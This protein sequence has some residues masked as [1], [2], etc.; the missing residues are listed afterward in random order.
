[1]AEVKPEPSVLEYDDRTTEA[2]KSV[3][4][5]MGQILGSF[6]GKFAIVGGLVPSLLI[7]GDEMKHVGSV[8]IDVSLDAEALGDGEYVSL[9]DALKENGYNQQDDLKVF[10][11]VRRIDVK[12]GGNHIDVVVDFLMPKSARFKKNRPPR[13]E[14]FVVIKA[15]GADIAL[16][17]SETIRVKG[18]MPEGGTNTVEIAV[19]SIP[20]LLVMKGY[21]I[22]GRKKDK[23]AYDIYYCVRNYEGGPVALAKD[24][25]E[26][27]AY[28]SA[29]IGYRYIL[30]KFESLD[31]FGPTC[32]RKF[33]E[34]TDILGERSAD[35]WQRDAFG[36]VQEWLKALGLLE[37]EKPV[38]A[39]V[40]AA[41]KK[42]PA[43]KAPAKKAAKK[44][45][46]KKKPAD[47]LQRSSPARQR[48]PH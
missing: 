43:K 32:V 40:R 25:R 30:E 11:L 45:A 2:V 33:V 35:Q 36:Q 38:A 29:E 44:H 18:Q 34:Q 3:L 8:D 5:E 12:D 27:L 13:I 47:K 22:K 6:R 1:M 24:C 14:N 41:A 16:K 21:A 7:S 19:A 39:K 10:Q 9:I 46:E 26:L 15:D 28:A 31:D 42:A 20:A 37:T 4:I 17:F 48:K 23:D